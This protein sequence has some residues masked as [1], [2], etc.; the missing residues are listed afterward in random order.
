MKSRS[1]QHQ[2]ICSSAQ[3]CN[4]SNSFLI[5]LP[6][7]LQQS[8]H[9][10]RSGF[11]CDASP[12][13]SYH[14]LQSPV[15]LDSKAVFRSH[16]DLLFLRSLHCL[17]L[18]KWLDSFVSVFFHVFL[19]PINDPHCHCFNFMLV[20]IVNMLL[21]VK[22]ILWDREKVL[23]SHVPSIPSLPQTLCRKPVSWSSAYLH[24]VSFCKGEQLC[25]FPCFLHNIYYI[26][27]FAICHSLLNRI[28]R[29]SQG[30]WGCWAT[31]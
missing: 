12:D 2:W 6:S 15:D 1:Q 29:K 4:A 7:A 18:E 23:P 3:P 31:G 25:L 19:L 17:L 10:G 13:T 9:N 14:A 5:P 22:A 21:K 11:V 28:S 20:S 8:N 30:L 16:L 27:P 26:C 24:S